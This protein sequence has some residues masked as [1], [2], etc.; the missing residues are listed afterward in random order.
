M[1]VIL[2]VN[3]DIRGGL[4][5]GSQGIVCG[6]EEFDLKKFSGV[7]HDRKVIPPYNLS[8]GEHAMLKQRQVT[9][10]MKAQQ[11][12]PPGCMGLPVRKF[13][14]RVLFHNGRKCAIYASCVVNAIGDKEPYSLLHRTQVPLIPGWAMS[15]HKSQGMTLDRVIVDLSKAIA[16]QVY[17]ALSRATGL[18]GLR[19][20]GDEEGLKTP[21]R[22]DKFVQDFLRSKF[23][24]ASW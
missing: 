3:L 12:A 4:V 6:F 13:W 20:D 2:Q 1:L 24:Q 9:E 11:T 14:P 22:G 17:V 8:S 23:E 10:F 21:W 19:I 18:E 7:K 16:G 15:V 5:N